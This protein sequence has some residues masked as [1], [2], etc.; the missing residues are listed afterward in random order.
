M[1]QKVFGHQG[2]ALFNMNNNIFNDLIEEYKNIFGGI[3]EDTGYEYRLNHGLRVF[4]YC[5]K[6][7]EMK[8][9]INK[10][11]N[12]KALLIAAL[13]HDIGKVKKINI[14]KYLVKYNDKDFKHDEIGGKIVSEYISKYLNDPDLIKKIGKIIRGHHGNNLT[15]Y[16]SYIIQDADRLDNYGMLLL[17]RLIAYNEH[18]KRN[19]E[20]MFE[21]WKNKSRPNAISQINEFHFKEIKFFAK[22]RFNKLDKLITNL[23]MEC[24]AEDI[25][26][27]NLLS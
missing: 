2:E 20:D 23:Y 21:Y 6:F 9:L 8:W 4:K 14:K 3:K 27:E 16:E 17:T 19:F 15:E 7:C 24:Q 22:K 10:R 26:E 13:F 11:I 1:K 5:Q 12:K 25:T 18:Q